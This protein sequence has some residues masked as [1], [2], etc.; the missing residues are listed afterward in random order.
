[1]GGY[2]LPDDVGYGI[3]K[4]NCPGWATVLHGRAW[5]G[6]CNQ[7]CFCFSLGLDYSAVL[8]MVWLVDLEYHEGLL[9]VVAL[10]KS[11]LWPWRGFFP[12][13]LDD[14]LSQFTKVGCATGVLSV[15]KDP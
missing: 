9:H 1:M 11:T 6:V 14:G 8:A 15:A 5:V 2:R 3:V 10:G 7:R 13:L 12:F 4:G